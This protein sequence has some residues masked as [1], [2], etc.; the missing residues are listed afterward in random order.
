M[1]KHPDNHEDEEG[2]EPEEDSQ[3]P[4]DE[5][6]EQIQE[7]LQADPRLD[8][9]VSPEERGGDLE[10]IQM[11]GL[12]APPPAEPETPPPAEPEPEPTRDLDPEQPLSFYEEGVADVDS[13]MAPTVDNEPPPEQEYP[14]E[15]DNRAAMEH[16][17]DMI[18]ELTKDEEARGPE[19]GT[20][21]PAEQES[22]PFELTPR[23]ESAEE[24]APVADV[25]LEPPPPLLEEAVS[26]PEAAEPEPP[27]EPPE[28]PAP[29]EEHPEE[30]SADAA[31]PLEEAAPFEFSP[32]EEEAPEPSL[33]EVE[34]TLDPSAAEPVS[35]V[36]FEA[37]EEPSPARPSGGLNVEPP[38]APEELGERVRI[39][40]IEEAEEAMYL[41]HTGPKT[42]RR[43]S[44]HR[45]DARRRMLR[46]AAGLIVL[47]AVAVGGYE[48]Y[49]WYDENV[50]NPTALYNEAVTMAAKGEYR[51]ASATYAAFAKR[52]PGS[53]LGADAQFAAAF[54]LQLLQP[55][56]VD[57][58]QQVYTRSI[59]MFKQFLDAY[60]THAK[61]PRARTLMGRLYYELGEY[62]QA[63]ELL[64]DPELRLLDPMAAVPAVRI[65]ARS[66]AK[67]GQDDS[68]RSY[69]LQAVGMQDNHTP[70]VDYTELG[71]LY[72]ALAERAQ[73]PAKRGE[74]EQLAVVEWTHA[75]Q[76]PGIDPATK[77]ELRA[78]M[79]VL[80]ER[81]QK[82]EAAA[83]EEQTNGA[84]DSAADS[85]SA[86]A[87]EDDVPWEAT[88]PALE[89]GTDKADTPSEPVSEPESDAGSMEQPDSTEPDSAA[90]AE[91]SEIEAQVE[92]PA[93]EAVYQV[94]AGDTLSGIAAAHGVS[95]ADLMEWNDLSQSV[96][97]VGQE[98]IIRSPNPQSTGPSAE[99]DGNEE[100]TS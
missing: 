41:R 59:E 14:S 32:V 20:P 62:Q 22:A 19:A 54:T 70:D 47:A 85:S 67:L 34:K 100:G 33:R 99:A 5:F 6:D 46:V 60:P 61:A 49:T 52:N 87:P 63:I 81:S 57:E 28:E 45:K 13:S 53:E 66:Y 80:R 71:T 50:S 43:R 51:Q 75:V 42:R 37:V 26:P 73:A 48:A 86:T 35:S 1:T 55:S 92:V 84:D 39:P 74:C 78:K 72:R 44:G 17:R 29:V 89:E 15:S 97:F 31:P 25:P 8:S 3:A 2:R 83:V 12:T 58:R 93:T 90:P 30:I 7:G 82:D 96:I 36:P 94:V 27:V 68:A 24:A 9:G 18:A 77:K 91:A 88:A 23:A 10:F 11:S 64:R 38:V 21:S 65:L 56:S 40:T 95:V 79:D 76:S 4:F 69:Y 16:L 98:L